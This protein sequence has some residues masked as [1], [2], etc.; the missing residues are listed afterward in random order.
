VQ[1]ASLVHSTHRPEAVHAATLPRWQSLGP[2]HGSPHCP[3]RHTPPPQSASASQA[4]HCAATQWPRLSGQ[5]LATVQAT[6]LPEAQCGASPEHCAFVLHVTG[7]SRPAV[8]PVE[9]SRAAPPSDVFPPAPAI[10]AALPPLAWLGNRSMLPVGAR[11]QASATT[12]RL[13]IGERL[14]DEC[15]GFITREPVR[16]ICQI[17]TRLRACFFASSAAHEG[18]EAIDARILRQR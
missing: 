4:T 11:A 10:S 15:F 1:S 5:S 9:A 17:A 18:T 2:L 14:E 8:P 7:L 6:Q 16:V 3:E 13:R 12:S